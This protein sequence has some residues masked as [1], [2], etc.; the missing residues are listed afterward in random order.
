MEENKILKL[1]KKYDIILDLDFEHI[2]F[3]KYFKNL[4]YF[5]IIYFYFIYKVNKNNEFFDILINIINKYNLFNSILI[6]SGNNLMTI[7]KF[8][9]IKNDISISIAGMNTKKKKGI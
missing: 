9:K 4:I 2:P 6:N 8:P 5:F 1:C 3:S 7:T